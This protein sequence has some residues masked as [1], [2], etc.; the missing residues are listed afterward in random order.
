MPIHDEHTIKQILEQSKTI[1]VVGASPKRWRDSNSIALFLA[2]R[3]YTVYPVNPRYE[4]ID[5][6]K[7]YPEVKSIPASIDIVDVF[8]QSSAV[9]DVVEDAVSAKAKTLWLQFGVVHEEAADQAEHAGMQVVMDRCIA[10]D[11]RQL[12]R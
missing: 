4:E 12:V 5:G 8:R 10:V 3:G 1:A 9:P 7:C 2:N 11:Y 6:M